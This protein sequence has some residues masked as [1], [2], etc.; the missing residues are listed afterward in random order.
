MTSPRWL[1]L[2]KPYQNPYSPVPLI[3][4]FSNLEKSTF[5]HFPIWIL[6]VL[7]WIFWG[8]GTDS[9]KYIPQGRVNEF[10]TKNIKNNS[11]LHSLWFSKIVKNPNFFHVWMCI[12]Y[13]LKMKFLDFWCPVDPW[14]FFN[15]YD[16]L[17]GSFW[18]HFETFE[19]CTIFLRGLKKFFFDVE[20]TS[21]GSFLLMDVTLKWVWKSC[22]HFSSRVSKS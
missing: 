7:F 19:T 8:V 17:G 5:V 14:S 9:P 1:F 12:W 11:F 2:G 20:D 21:F 13:D 22:F 18:F 15:F 3:L 6:E 16:G 10:V 4:Y